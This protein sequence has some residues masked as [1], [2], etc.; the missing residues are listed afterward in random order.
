MASE[1]WK[2]LTSERIQDHRVSI[3]AAATA[4]AIVTTFLQVNPPLGGNLI[5]A[6]H[7]FAV[8]IPV[9]VFLF[10]A[11]HA[12]LEHKGGWH[13]VAI[14]LLYVASLLIFWSGMTLTIAH[15]NES[16]AWLFVGATA[17]GLLLLWV[18]FSHS[19]NR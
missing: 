13:A 2:A 5:D 8:S 6:L 18:S 7:L 19:D 12:G 16:A 17:F 3:G 14:N 15:L 10:L 4:V 11:H 9:Q 1:R